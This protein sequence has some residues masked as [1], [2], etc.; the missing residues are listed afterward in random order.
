MSKST[1]YKLVAPVI[2]FVPLKTLFVG[3]NGLLSK[4]PLILNS[5]VAKRES[6]SQAINPTSE[7][8]LFI[9]F[10]LFSV[11]DNSSGTPCNPS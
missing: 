6:P 4:F 5:S 11:I 3:F 2:V 9:T 10:K 1:L 8:L 7:L